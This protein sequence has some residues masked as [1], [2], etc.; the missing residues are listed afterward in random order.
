MLIDLFCQSCQNCLRPGS[1]YCVYCGTPLPTNSM[2]TTQPSARV[3]PPVR[4]EQTLMAANDLACEKSSIASNYD[5]SDSP[6][7]WYQRRMFDM[8]GEAL[9]AVIKLMN[10]IHISCIYSPVK[11]G[12]GMHESRFQMLIEI[13]DQLNIIDSAVVKLISQEFKAKV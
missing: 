11:K 7:E 12:G 2:L 4:V 3:L 5:A 8:G 1:Q 9:R 6:N 10:N 13:R